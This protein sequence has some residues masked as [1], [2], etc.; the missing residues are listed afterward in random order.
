MIVDCKYMVTPTLI[1]LLN[2]VYCD[3]IVLIARDTS[4]YIAI[5]GLIY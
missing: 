4:G 5:N 3:I 2:I 1:H